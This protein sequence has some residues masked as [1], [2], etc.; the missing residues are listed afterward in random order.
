MSFNRVIFGVLM[1]A[2]LLS[3]RP[4]DEDLSV[5]YIWGSSGRRLDVIRPVP[6]T[7]EIFQLSTST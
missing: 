4:G 2:C 1:G 7:V 5:S 6:T 3:F